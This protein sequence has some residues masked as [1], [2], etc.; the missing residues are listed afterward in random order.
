MKI[1]IIGD[2]TDR[3]NELVRTISIIRSHADII[4]INKDEGG[5]TINRMEGKSIDRFEKE[6]LILKDS[7]MYSDTLFE[8][9]EKPSNKERE[10]RKGKG[11]YPNPKY[12][13]KRK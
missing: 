7:A 13:H 12:L 8:L 6:L 1:I 10:K 9:I 5:G 4:V 2:N 3:L 11:H